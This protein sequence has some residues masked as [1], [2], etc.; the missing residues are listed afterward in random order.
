[1]LLETPMYKSLLGHTKAESLRKLQ[2]TPET[3]A[4]AARAVL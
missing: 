2:I 1:M 3:Y 4:G